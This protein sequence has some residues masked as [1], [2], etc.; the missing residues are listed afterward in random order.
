METSPLLLGSECEPAKGAG[1]SV[2]GDHQKGVS[3][4]EV[5]EMSP[6]YFI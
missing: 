5:V 1:V 3:I 4:T 2:Y 6:A